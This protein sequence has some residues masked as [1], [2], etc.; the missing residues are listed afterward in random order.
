MIG[1]G[2]R[3]GSNEYTC[4]YMC[5]F[6][7]LVAFPFGMPPFVTIVSTHP[8]HYMLSHARYRFTNKVVTRCVYNI[9]CL[10]SVCEDAAHEAAST[11]AKALSGR[12]DS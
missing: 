3:T 4:V 9:P 10:L 11:P 1:G 12:G 7:P 8:W 5:L 6:T 2:V